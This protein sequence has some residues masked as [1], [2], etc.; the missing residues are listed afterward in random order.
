M[1]APPPPDPAEARQTGN[2]VVH[3]GIRWQR[4]SSGALRWW[5]D[6]DARWVRFASGGDAPPRPP[7]WER[8]R[9]SAG[10]SIERP[11]WRSPYRIIPVVLLALV[12]IIG[13]T[14]AVRGSGGQ[15]AAEDKAAHGLIG[16]C[17]VQD[18]T[19]GGEP[20]YGAKGAACTAVGAV[21]K[22]VKVLPGTPGAPT[23][24]Q[25]T[26]SVQLAYKGVRYPHQLCVVVNG[27][28]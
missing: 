17:L 11:P 21:V 20:R 28:G 24:P 1:S 18:G 9:R 26:T 14:Q 7:G 19:L 22:V 23:C 4:A 5:D 6:D 16:K 12:I 27:G 13:V 10:L 3:R 8:S 2:D 25:A 15:V